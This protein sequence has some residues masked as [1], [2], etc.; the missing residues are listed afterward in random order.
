MS[1]DDYVLRGG[2]RHGEFWRGRLR[3]EERDLLYVAAAGFDPRM[4]DGAE[5]IMREGG[6]G[7]RDCR[8][9][10]LGGAGGPAAPPPLAG[11]A[12]ENMERMARLFGGRGREVQTADVAQGTGRDVDIQRGAAELVVRDRDYEA[13]ADIVVDVSSMPTQVLFP[14]LGKIVRR[15]SG[16]GRRPAD[17]GR[18]PNLFVVASE[19]LA[20]DRAITRSGLDEEA[21]FV[22]GF[23]G[24]ARPREEAAGPSVWFPVLGENR[25]DELVR[26]HLA[27][28][29]DETCPVVPSPSADPR[30]ADGILLEYRRIL[31]RVGIDPRNMI[32]ASEANPFDVYRQIRDAVVRYDRA[33]RPVGAR[34]F[35]ISPMS[36][37]LMSVGAFLAAYELT[38]EMG[39]RLG[40]GVVGAAGHRFERPG[41]GRI[42]DL[43]TLWVCGDCYEP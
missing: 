29:P 28:G 21:G 14:L 16:A 15:L 9:A 22:Y 26:L 19:D 31:R 3:G 34:R 23:L 4:C 36:G 18:G 1:W 5:S 25:A 43:S 27:I 6:A 30:R 20:V 35:A 8:L 38:Y 39:I 41:A 12:E 33:L 37:K 11:L 2:R 42:P 7:R 32:Y 24:D 17:G 13:Y 10:L 40:V